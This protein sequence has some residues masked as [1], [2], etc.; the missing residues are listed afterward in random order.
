[1]KLNIVGSLEYS[2][3]TVVVLAAIFSV[4]TSAQAQTQPIVDA[5]SL[6]QQQ[7]NQPNRPATPPKLDL[8]P[9]S[10]EELPTQSPKG[11]EADQTTVIVKTFALAGS[12]TVFTPEQLQTVLGSFVNRPLS[13]AQL[14]E[15]ASAITQLYRQSGYFLARAYLPKQDVSAGSVTIAVTEGV[16]DANNGVRIEGTELRVNPALALGIVKI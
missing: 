15:A 12:V 13:L 4:A 10:K 8:K 6:L 1:M 7:Q 14:Q 3:C 11:L 9:L 16:L 2:A 5:G